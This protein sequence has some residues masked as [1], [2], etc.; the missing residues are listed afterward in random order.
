MDRQLKQ[1]ALPCRLSGEHFG[2]GFSMQC[3]ERRAL[4]A[5]AIPPPPEGS[6]FSRR[7]L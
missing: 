3:Q 5:A 6:G 2:G 4:R 1:T 7:P